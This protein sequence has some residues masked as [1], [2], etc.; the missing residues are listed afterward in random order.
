VL[1]YDKGLSQLSIVTPKMR[2]IKRA[3]FII[4]LLHEIEKG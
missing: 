3:I 2:Y 4:Y 1:S